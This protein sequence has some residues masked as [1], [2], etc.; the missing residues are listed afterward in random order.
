MPQNV[1]SVPANSSTV[2]YAFLF[3]QFG[4]YICIS[5]RTSAAVFKETNEVAYVRLLT[6]RL[7]TKEGLHLYRNYFFSTDF[8]LQVHGLRW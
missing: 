6:E 1:R 2:Q 8:M 4:R 7:L 3:C 5:I